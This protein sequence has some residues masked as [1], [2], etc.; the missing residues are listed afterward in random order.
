MPSICES[1]QSVLLPSVDRSNGRLARS[2]FSPL[3]TSDF[4]SPQQNKG[5]NG[6]LE[7]MGM[8]SASESMGE[9]RWDRREMERDSGAGATKPTV[10]QY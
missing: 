5:G 8:I 7:R 6:E 4:A 1:T 2:F 10:N 9:E 3:P